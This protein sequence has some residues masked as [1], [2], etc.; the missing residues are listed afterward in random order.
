M[1]P[2]YVILHIRA[3]ILYSCDSWRNSFRNTVVCRILKRGKRAGCAWKNLVSARELENKG[4]ELKKKSE[5]TSPLCMWCVADMRLIF[6]K[7]SLTE[8]VLDPP[9]QRVFSCLEICST[10]IRKRQLAV[11]IQSDTSFSFQEWYDN[12]LWRRFLFIMTRLFNWWPD[13]Y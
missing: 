10:F 4:L 8:K 2:F 7:I 6:W 12:Y 3:L 11:I 1:G 13:T 9:S 5:K